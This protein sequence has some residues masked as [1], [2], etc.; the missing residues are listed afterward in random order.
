MQRELAELVV[1]SLEKQDGPKL[2]L[3]EVMGMEKIKSDN[4]QIYALHKGDCTVLALVFPEH[5]VVETRI[6]NWKKKK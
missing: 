4:L 1:K 3:G 5:K 6:V 2:K